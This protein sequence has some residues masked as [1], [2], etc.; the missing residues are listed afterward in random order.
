MDQQTVTLAYGFADPPISEQWGVFDL[1][2]TVAF[3][4]F[5]SPAA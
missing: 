4:C 2:C 5:I 1:A 3:R